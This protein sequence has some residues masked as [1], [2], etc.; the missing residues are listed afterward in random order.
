M[1]VAC[2]AQG[3]L[4]YTCA[5]AFTHCTLYYRCYFQSRNAS[6]LKIAPNS[7]LLPGV[8]IRRLP[9]VQAC[10]QDGTAR[11]D[12]L[13]FHGLPQS[14]P[15][16]TDGCFRLIFDLHEPFWSDVIKDG[17]SAK[18]ADKILLFNSSAVPL[19]TVK[20]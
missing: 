15:V 6:G 11:Q 17:S 12:I 9:A 14:R 18:T 5:G 13:P 4:E 3:V 2:T 1:L 16:E 19:V 10:C 20:K 8:F 7:L